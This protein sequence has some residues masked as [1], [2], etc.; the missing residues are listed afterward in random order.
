MRCDRD[1]KNLCVVFDG[2]ITFH[3]EQS[4]AFAAWEDALEKLKVLDYEASF[5]KPNNLQPFSR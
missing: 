3:V 1:S 2:V 5:C 4:T